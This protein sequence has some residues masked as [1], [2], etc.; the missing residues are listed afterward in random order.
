MVKYKKE[1]YIYENFNIFKTF[2]LKTQIEKCVLC[3]SDLGTAD[4]F[5]L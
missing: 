2:S 4:G 5:V 3:N 1:I